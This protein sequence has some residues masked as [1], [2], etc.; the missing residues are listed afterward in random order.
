MKPALLPCLSKS[1]LVWT[2]LLALL[3]LSPLLP[4]QTFVGTNQPGGATN[5]TFTLPA[6]VTNL[7]LTISNTATA[8]SHLLLKKG[9]EPTDTDAD[10]AARVNGKF[11]N[12]INLEWPEFAATNYGL[13]VRT[14]AGSAAQA[15]QVILSTNRSD[16]RLAA[17]PVQKPITFT[18]TGTLAAG[19]WNYFQVDVPTNLPGW[20][21]VLTHAGSG[22]PDLYVRRGALPTTTLSD[23][24][25]TGQL[26]DSLFFPAAEATNHTYFIGVRLPSGS[27]DYTLSA[28][29]DQVVPLNWDPG[30]TQAGTEVYTNQS[31]T[32]GDYYFR[33]VT[34]GT[35][36]G[37][38][39]L[40]LRVLSGEADLYLRKGS[41]TVNLTQYPYQS[42]NSGSDGLVFSSLDFA[43]AQEWHAVVRAT[44][45][46]QWTLMSGEVFVHDL[47]ALAPPGSLASSTNVTVQ[48]EGMVFFK[49]TVPTNTMAWRLWLTNLSTDLLVRKSFVPHPKNSS[50]WDLKKAGQMLIV[51]DYLAANTFDGYYFVGLSSPPGTLV[52]LDSQQ[53]RVT[54]LPFAYTTN[55]SVSGYGYTTFRLQVPVEQIAW[56]VSVAP[57]VG[58]PDLAVRRNK[59]PNESNNEGFSEAGPGVTD[60]V[61]LV[62]QTLSDGTFFVTVYGA[63]PQTFTL[64]TGPPLITDIHFDGRVTNDLATWTGWRF[65]RV[66][67]TAEQ[68]GHL[69]WELL[70]FGA[71]A[72][73][74]IALRRNAVP[75]RWNYR[76]SDADPR[77]FTSGH[78]DFSSDTNWFLQRPGH[79]ADV[80][81]VGIYHP[82]SALGAF[83]LDTH[84]LRATNVVFDGGRWAVTDQPPGF[85]RYY[86]IDVPT[87]ANVLGWDVRLANVT[88]GLPRLAVRRDQLPVSLSTTPWTAPAIAS[89]WPSGSCWGASVDWTARRYA[90][91]GV[92]EYGRLLAMGRGRPLEPGTYYVG[93]IN[94]VNSEPMSYELVSRGI[95]EGLSIAVADLAFAGGTAT[96]T[97]LP[98]REAA[99]F[100]TVIPSNTPSWKLKLTATG[101]ESLLV[102]LKDVLPNVLPAGSAGQTATGASGKLMKKLDNEHFVLLPPSGQSNLV[103]GTY[104]LAV[105]G[106]GMNPADTQHIGTNSSSFSL[107]SFGPLPIVNLGTLFAELT[108]SNFLEGGE[109]A[110]YQFTVPPNTVSL[111]LWLTNEVWGGNF[112]GYP[113]MDYRGDASLPDPSDD[114]GVEDGSLSQQNDTNLITVVNPAPGLYSVIVKAN[115]R[116]ANVYSNA[117]YTLRIVGLQLVDVAFDGGSATITNQ[118]RGDTWRYFRIE[119]PANAL[120]WDLRLLNLSNDNARLVVRRDLLPDGFSTHAAPS[121]PWNPV[122]SSN[123]PSGYQW[124]AGYDW[125]GCHETAEG[126]NAVGHVIAMGLGNPLEPGTYYA[127]VS[128][129]STSPLRYTLLSRGIGGLLSLR[130]TSLDFTNGQ[131]QVTNLLAREAAYYRV[132]VPTNVPRWKVR[133]AP[134]TGEVLFAVQK[135]CLPNVGADLTTDPTRR[136]GGKKMQKAGNDHLLMLANDD[137]TNLLAGTYYLAVVSEGLN[138]TLNSYG[139]GRDS[140]DSVLQSFGVVPPVSLGTLGPIPILYPN[141][142]EG[143]EVKTFQFIVPPGTEALEVIMTNLVGYPQLTLMPG[144]QCPDPDP[145]RGWSQDDYGTEGGQVPHEA[146]RFILTVGSPT[147]GVHT[148]TIKAD[149][150]SNVGGYPNVTNVL[151]ARTMASVPVAFDGGTRSVVG[152]LD[153][154]WSFFRVEVPP[155][156]L[157][158]DVRL[159]NVTSGSPA[160]VVCRGL[161]PDEFGTLANGGP[162]NAPSS[163]TSWPIGYQ[164][165]ADTDWTGYP[166]SA[167]GTNETG[168][169]LAMGRGNPLE[170]GTY[171]VG[172]VNNST[173]NDPTPMSYTLVS[174]GIGDGMKLPVTPLDFAGGSASQLGLGVREAAYFRVEVPTNAPSWKVRMEAFGGDALLCVQKGALPNVNASDNSTAFGFRA[175]KRMQ[176][177]GNE[178]YLLLPKLGQTV[179]EAGTYYLAVVSEGIN[180]DSAQRRVGWESSD[181]GLE[182]QGPLAVTPLGTISGSHLRPDAVE[183]G[184]VKAYQF[185]L[186]STPALECRLEGRAGGPI[187]TL[188]TN[189]QFPDPNV[190]ESHRYSKYGVENGQARP[191][192]DSDLITLANPTPGLF[193]LLVKGY[194]VENE[195][196]D[197]SYTLHLAPQVIPALNFAG[198]FNTNGLTNAVSGV[199]ADNQRVFYEVLIPRTNFHG[200]PVLGWVLRVTQTYGQASVRARKDSLPSDAD[201]NGMPLT[202][203]QALIVPPFLSPGHWYV[204][205][206][207]SGNTG[208]TL[209]SGELFLQ[210]PPWEM[211]PVGQPSPTPG[212]TAPEFGDTGVGTN[213]LALPGDQGIDLENGRFHY[214]AFLVPTNNGGLV[215]MVL[216]AI[217]GNPDLY[218]RFGGPP[219]LS[220]GLAGHLRNGPLVDR[221]LTAAQFTQYANWASLNGRYEAGFT[222]GLWFL[223]VRAGGGSNVRYRLRLSTGHILDLPINGSLADQNLNGG[224]WRYYRVQVPGI[225]SNSTPR[226]WAVSF[227]QHLGN[228]VLYVRDTQPPGQGTT[229]TDFRD[230]KDDDKDQGPYADFDA[231]GAYALS[232][233]PLRPGQTYYLGFRALNDATFS[234]SSALG[235]P[236]VN[237]TNVVAFYGGMLTNVLPPSGQM[238]VQVTVPAEA[239]RWKHASIHAATVKV[240]LEQGTLPKGSGDHWAGS[241]ANTSLDKYLRAPNNWPW[242]PGSS[243]FLL[244]TNTSGSSQPFS[245]TMDGRNPSTD[246]A[247]HDGLPDAYELLYFGSTTAQAGATDGDGD[248]VNNLNE[249]QEGSHPANAADYNPRLFVTAPG[250][251]VILDPAQLYYRLGDTVI[252]GAVPDAGLV[253]KG[254]TG[255]AFGDANPLYLTMDTNKSLTAV[256]TPPNDDFADAILLAG[257]NFV[258]TGHNHGATKEAGEPYHAGNVGGRSVWWTWIAPTN[259]FVTNSTVGSTFDTTLAIYT[260]DTLANLHLIA[261]DNNGGGARA[262]RIIFHATSGTP[263]HFAVD[264][265]NGASGSIQLSLGFTPSFGR[266]LPPALLP[267]GGVGLVL[268][269]NDGMSFTLLTSTN[270]TDWTP[271]TTETCTG[272][273]IRFT[274]PQPVHLGQRFYRAIKP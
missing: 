35:S 22:N 140:T 61:T 172:V 163:S 130:V 122:G 228:V 208:F 144:D 84:P 132:E 237:V 151:F 223:A 218:I 137:Q 206:K 4:A 68:L 90:A 11:T 36:L 103:A 249:L 266:F 45:G 33:I 51:P 245:L 146:T 59:V 76:G 73:T 27:A 93:V 258:V 261:Q 9:G 3:T 158:W 115:A 154:R 247:D 171:F 222:N 184:E 191:W 134:T 199:L 183:G 112:K 253:F 233:P 168:R 160:L 117:A 202:Q 274:D 42:A 71:P 24:S 270:L 54:D 102:V 181:F 238:F 128:S 141:T 189:A 136:A 174:R 239:S 25:S 268:Y 194:R 53:Q 109:L 216:E 64:R 182:S 94:A 264:G 79:Q 166:Y 229:L 231:P 120:G 164:W 56:Q 169:L 17:Y 50:T 118:D 193:T 210:R 32:G 133:L 7:S 201:P 48:P 83:V 60:S 34:G 170:P 74:E 66:Y 85:M 19:A 203:D 156:A 198:Y 152:Q 55:L 23:K 38:W 30:L 148:L 212:L 114:Y 157:G 265:F 40:A 185:W 105:V 77:V 187:M 213:G 18:T 39:R 232:I 227:A 192:Q 269:A 161:L 145:H 235:G 215:R 195:L 127:G 126:N 273:V 10:F 15:F 100:R 211:Q 21:V 250:G 49:T 104:Y 236:I 92:D 205:V 244:I 8:F 234:V 87:N 207:G 178:H 57:T 86:R 13:R 267:T 209:T 91:E 241:G 95:G 119:V 98:P 153:Q 230:W 113:F 214:Y 44:R 219:S 225:T 58:N 67:D 173:P 200:D 263:Y 108:H 107:T 143:G 75:G 47:G 271:L 46:A 155:T 106:E 6:G 180:P 37:A 221:S 28:E 12:A 97:T 116:P 142:V 262:S 252:L 256:F 131:V 186:A 197:A 99:Y 110:A 248:G 240:Y 81:Y 162:W 5:F 72:N 179:I 121:V 176:K 226:E 2:T 101:G 69:G 29:I 1:R 52:G 251:R 257:T 82:S 43:A 26:L 255:D 204:E 62:P 123:W 14:P 147:S 16:L 96:G 70:L 260:N 272:G 63:S 124:A 246:D 159:T 65:F 167:A 31:P 139:I 149:Y 138:P 129:V 135:D 217:S 220:H 89:A 196:P 20:R 125:T 78:V 188:A 242:L 41:F 177:A 175:G 243:Y 150:D 224:D 190:T 254:W 259:G 80:W 165:A 88:R 111:E